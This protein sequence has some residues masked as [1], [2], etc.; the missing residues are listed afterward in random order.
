MKVLA[1][2]SVLALT[3]V[4][5][6][7]PA[8]A[9]ETSFPTL[10]FFTAID[11][12]REQSPVIRAATSTVGAAQAEVGFART[13]YLPTLD[14]LWQTNRATRNNVFGMLL[15]QSVIPSISG[16]VLGGTDNTSTWGSVG[17]ALFSW[18]MFDFGRRGATVRAA[19]ED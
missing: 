11:R 5:Y 14:I 15:P 7:A 1:H 9:Q 6:G 8:G 19:Q 13:A 18:E 16:P 3:L 2:V 10:D 12:A 17:G 4:L